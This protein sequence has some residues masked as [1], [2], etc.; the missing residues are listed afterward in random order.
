MNNQKSTVYLE[1]LGCAKNLVD[2]EVMLGCLS[3]DGYRLTRIIEEAHIIVVNTCAFI[4]EATRE[5]IETILWIAEHKKRG[6]C[7]Y[8]IVCGCLSQRY[9]DELL[10]ELPEVDLFLGTGEFQNISK[11]IQNLFHEKNSLKMQTDRPSFLMAEDTPRVLSA[12]GSSAYLKIS[13]GCSHLCTYCTI[14]AIRGPF[15]ARP[16]GSIIKEAR[17]L[18]ESGI[19]EINLISQD[20]TQYEGLAGLLQELVKVPDIKWIRLLYCHPLNLDM[21][22]INVLARE[23]KLCPYMD[24][25]L[26]HIADPVLKRMGR[27]VTR[28][29]I[30]VLLQRINRASPDIALRTTFM[31]GF[32]GETEK[33]FEDL[34]EFAAQVRFDHLG[35]FK[36]CDEEGTPASRL[37]KKVPEEI[38]KQR[39]NRLMRLQSKISKEK[40]RARKGKEFE[41]LVEDISSNEKYRLQARAAFQAPEVD[42]VVFINE[43]FPIGSFINVRITKAFTYDLAG[44]AVS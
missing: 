12:T 42:G 18:S 35:A 16:A 43:D 1:S 22:I 11:H 14:P 32:P 21:D 30:E 3:R 4:E 23:E 26:Q 17:N 33:D 2:S 37:N 10:K 29:K 20:T 19:R 24:V 9:Q 34:L 15:Q 5:S 41:V 40:N 25:P 39:Y 27:K 31:V 38:K 36:Y 44:K 13:E 7:K 28:K 6:S 8:L